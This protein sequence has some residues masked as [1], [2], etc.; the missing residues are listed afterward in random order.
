MHAG[1]A[2]S[3]LN[4]DPPMGGLRGVTPQERRRS[5]LRREYRLI[6]RIV[7]G[8]RPW[9]FR[10]SKNSRNAMVNNCGEQDERSRS[11]TDNVRKNWTEL[12]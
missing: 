2:V 12:H 5:N 4:F 6:E 10:F 8:Y 11:N 7:D 1:F 3:K 9:N